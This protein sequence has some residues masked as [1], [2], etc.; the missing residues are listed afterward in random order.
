MGHLPEKE[1]NEVDALAGACMLVRKDVL[2]KTLGF[3]EQFFM[4]AEDID[5]S[6]RVQQA[7]Y[8]NYYFPQ[9]TI[10][11]FKGES[12]RKDK[13]YVRLFYKAMLQFTRKHFRG[14][15][16]GL[17]LFFLESA[18]KLQAALAGMFR[19]SG[20]KKHRHGGSNKLLLAG[21]KELTEMLAAKIS[22]VNK[23]D[24]TG[25]QENIPL[26]P[27]AL[28][29]TDADTIIFCEGGGLTYKRI[30][31]IIDT[32]NSSAHFKIHAAGSASIVGSTTKSSQGEVIG[33]ENP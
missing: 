27:A 10:L 30:I 6:Y 16:S 7:G 28:R 24:F 25:Y 2:D 12:T 21:E 33:L 17:S 13:R 18:I 14:N 5:L 22:R 31:G 32:L 26:Q 29:Q 23:A 9:S 8:K 4:Y 11:H 3:D 1:I 19:Q 15:M 20:E